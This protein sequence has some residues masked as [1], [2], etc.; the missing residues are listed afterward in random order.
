MDGL[1]SRLSNLQTRAKNFAPY[2]E[3][4]NARQM[5]DDLAEDLVRALN[6]MRVQKNALAAKDAEESALRGQFQADIER[7]RELRK[8][9]GNNT[10]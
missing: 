1:H 3:N 9:V 8:V 7:Y 5:P 4:P 6:E 2:S 10:R